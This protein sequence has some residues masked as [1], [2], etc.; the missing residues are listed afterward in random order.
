[1]IMMF[2]AFFCL[3]VPV[4]SMA[5]PACIRK[6]RKAAMSSHRWSMMSVN[7]S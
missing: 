3:T 4:S 7:S 5:K 6:T 2:F 1:M